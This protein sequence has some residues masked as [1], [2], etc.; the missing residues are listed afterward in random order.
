LVTPPE[1]PPEPPVSLVGFGALVVLESLSFP[2]ELLI[3]HQ[4]SFST[5]HLPSSSS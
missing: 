1:P 4:S 3:K 2:Q 5:P